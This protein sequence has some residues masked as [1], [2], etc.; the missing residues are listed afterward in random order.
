MLT[1]QD[2]KW[3]EKGLW[4]IQELIRML[5]CFRL[6]TLGKLVDGEAVHAGWGQTTRAPLWATPRSRGTHVVSEW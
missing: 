3:I 6:G 2:K 5:V 1:V 4:H